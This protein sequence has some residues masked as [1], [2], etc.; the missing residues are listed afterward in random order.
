MSAGPRSGPD[1]IAN[2]LAIAAKNASAELRMGP[3][4]GGRMG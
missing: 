1:A 4:S 3:W 2:D